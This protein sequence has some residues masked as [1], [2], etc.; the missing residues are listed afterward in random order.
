MNWRLVAAALGCAGV[1]G[2]GAG[3]ASYHV[4]RNADPTPEPPEPLF[5][6]TARHIEGRPAWPP[7]NGSVAFNHEMIALLTM[8]AEAGAA[9]QA[10][11]RAEPE[12]PR[13]MSRQERRRAQQEERARLRAER[14]H[15]GGDRP[16][17]EQPRGTV[18]IVVRDRWG[19]VQVHRVERDDMRPR[20]YVPAPRRTFGPFGPW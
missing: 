19:R 6:M 12:P 10:Y 4:G 15:A 3:V 8:G 2:V 9:A 13:R 16:A 18:E 5:L 17:R 11:A 20:A 14:E 7:P 1:L